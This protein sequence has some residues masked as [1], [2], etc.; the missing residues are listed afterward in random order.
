MVGREKPIA[1]FDMDGTLFDYEGRLIRDLNYLKAPEELELTR[2]NFQ[3]RKEDKHI[4]ERSKLIT[5]NE[6]WWENLPRL[7]LG[8]DVL[9]I[10]Q[11]LDYRIVIATQGPSFNPHAWSGKKRCIDKNFDSRFDVNITRDKG[12][13]YG[14]VFV[15]D[16]PP[17]LS[18]WLEHRKRGQVIM[19]ANYDNAYFKHPQVLRYDGTN[20][21][22]VRKT[23]ERVKNR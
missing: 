18:G 13:V 10:A 3:K 23:L 22:E 8:W 9:E 15:D 6:S 4:F 19:P 5:H 14:K 7:Q 2:E 17:Y 11:E 16:Y 1:L 21:E 20:L 12:L